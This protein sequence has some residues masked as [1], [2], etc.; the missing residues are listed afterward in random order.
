MI[1]SNLFSRKELIDLIKK[2]PRTHDGYYYFPRFTN[3]VMQ[4]GK[5]QDNGYFYDRCLFSRKMCFGDD[6]LKAF[7]S[8]K[9]IKYDIQL[10]SFIDSKLE[11]TLKGIEFLHIKDKLIDK[12]YTL[13][14]LID[15]TIY[16]T[17]YKY[18]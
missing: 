12:D 2:S 3:L 9:K 10:S 7:M 15:T 18:S 4:Q 11:D 14:E 1:R 13:E 5:E 17:K 16:I 6:D 8:R